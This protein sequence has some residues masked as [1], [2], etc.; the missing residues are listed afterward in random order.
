M[1]PE[2]PSRSEPWSHMSAFPWYVNT[3]ENRIMEAYMSGPSPEK[4]NE[5]RRVLVATVDALEPLG[6][7]SPW[8]CMWPYCPD[9]Y[10][11]CVPCQDPPQTEES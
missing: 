6:V 8:G 5:I 10:D 1:T 9:M 2:A 11:R 7:R 3:I 4:Y